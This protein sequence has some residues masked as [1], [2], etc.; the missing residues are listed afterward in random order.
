MHRVLNSFCFLMV[1]LGMPAVSVLAAQTSS[2]EQDGWEQ[3]VAHGQSLQAE[4][5]YGEA[6]A[7]FEAALD[8][9]KT[10]SQPLAIARILNALALVKQIR[11]DF[12]SA[13]ALYNRAI[14]ICNLHPDD[15]LMAVI[16]LNTARL[17]GAVSRF[18][19]AKAL[20]QRSLALHQALL[21]KNH[22]SVADSLDQLAWIDLRLGNY[23][24]SKR[25]YTLS[26]A[27]REKV[28]TTNGLALAGTLNDLGFLEY[29][30]GD[31][32]HA[33]ECFRRVLALRRK[34]QGA[35][36]PDVAD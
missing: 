24:E 26:L 10:T 11:G 5:R 35:S 6:Q 18:E 16:L 15:R 33:D 21:G 9:A 12:A 27:I 36:H 20:A 13:E 29:S 4:G 7:V 22:P 32:V 25:N 19:D 2:T 1:S 31:Y 17:N 28:Q 3:L 23:Q 8:E 30:T 34:A 14:E